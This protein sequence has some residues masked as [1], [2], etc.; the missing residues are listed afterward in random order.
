LVLRKG[1]WVREEGLRLASGLDE[2]PIALARSE[3]F[4]PNGSQI[5][6][7]SWVERA[8]GYDPALH[9]IEDVGLQI[10]IAML[11]GR[12]L[13]A[14]FSEPLFLYRRRSRSF[15]K[16]DAQRFHHACYLSIQRVEA[17]HRSTASLTP[18]RSRELAQIYLSC[19]RFFARH[20]P[21]L[22][23]DVLRH[24]LALDPG[25]VPLAPPLLRWAARAFGYSRA[26]RLSVWRER[27]LGRR[28]KG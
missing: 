12:F 22:F 4:V 9:P 5:F 3:G 19:A 26:E 13:V 21:P 20:A 14:P 17:H 2:G 24:I 28:P 25:F 1:R 7:R 10:R 18:A 16:S 6:R 15:S 11:G 23:E 27:I 8:G